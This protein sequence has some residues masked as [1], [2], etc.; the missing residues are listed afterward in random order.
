MPKLYKVIHPLD[1]IQE[2]KMNTENLE[3]I[4]M[5]PSVLVSLF[6]LRIY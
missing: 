4:K 6:I 5:I 2:E 3:P 1:D